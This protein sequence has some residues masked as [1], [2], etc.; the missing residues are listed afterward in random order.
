LGVGRIQ[1][2]TTAVES[3]QSQQRFAVSTSLATADGAKVSQLATPVTQS[4][5]SASNGGTQQ[6]VV[7]WSTVLASRYTVASSS[8]TTATGDA[9][10]DSSMGVAVPVEWSYLV[11]K[12]IEIRYNGQV[13]RAV[14][15]DTGGFLSLGRALDLQP[16]VCAA[17]GVGTGDDWG[18]RTVEWR[19]VS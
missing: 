10:T 13:V 9:M 6:P 12:T 19:I 8:D 14:I 2:A 11:G 15:N 16:G 4:A 7:G 18:V 17:F 3:P 5:D 1:S